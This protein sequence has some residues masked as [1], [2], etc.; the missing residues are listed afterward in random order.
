MPVPQWA[1]AR[2]PLRLAAGAL[3]SGWAALSTM[4]RWVI[5]FVLDPVHDDVRLTYA[6]AQAGL[7][8]G[9]STIYDAAVSTS[10]P[11][12][13]PVDAFIRYDSTPFLAWLFVPLTAFSE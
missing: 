10:A 11:G 7:R 3:A 6:A 13:A 9:W 1:A 8:D 4:L 12:A 5:P 2:P